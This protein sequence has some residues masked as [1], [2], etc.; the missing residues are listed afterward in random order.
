MVKTI[1]NSLNKGTNQDSKIQIVSI[2]QL[3]EKENI[4]KMLSTKIISKLTKEQDIPASFLAVDSEGHF[5]CISIYNV[6]SQTI[7]LKIK[8][9][10]LVTIKDPFIKKVQFE[11]FSYQSAQ[12]FDFTKIWADKKSLTHE[13]FN[14]NTVY[15]EAFEK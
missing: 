15:N 13:D 1:P 4:N 2:K 5:L 3:K 7:D 6:K 9:D 12:V 8:K 14:P 11:G 10:T